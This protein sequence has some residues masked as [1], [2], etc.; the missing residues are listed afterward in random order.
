LSALYQTTKST[1]N[2]QSINAPV[3][4]FKGVRIIEVK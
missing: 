2:A 4:P 1:K 3:V